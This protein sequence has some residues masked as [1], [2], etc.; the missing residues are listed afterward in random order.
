MVEHVGQ[1]AVVLLAHL[2]V[3]ARAAGDNQGIRLAA[4]DPSAESQAAHDLVERRREPHDGGLER[5]RGV[6]H[7][8][9]ERRDG[10]SPAGG[11]RS[12][13]TCTP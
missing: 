12:R 2:A 7:L 11:R 8:I 6:L 1:S 9:E 13:S 3:E 5:N 4:L 10:A